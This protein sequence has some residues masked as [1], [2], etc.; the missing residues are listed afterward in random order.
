MGIR[1]N[2]ANKTL[3]LTKIAKNSKEADVSGINFKIIA[4]SMAKTKLE[5]GPAIAV[6][7]LSLTGDLKFLGST[8]TGLA[9]PNAGI[10]LKIKNIG[11]RTVPIMSM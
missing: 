9:Q 7:K 8:I 11:T 1:L 2:T 5:S 4:A 3:I 6:M 10:P